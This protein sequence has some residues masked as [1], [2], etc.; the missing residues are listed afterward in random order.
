MR[1]KLSETKR[2][3][4]IGRDKSKCHCELLEWSRV[5]PF[6][7]YCPSCH[8]TMVYEDEIIFHKKSKMDKFVEQLVN[9]VDV[10]KK[11]ELLNEYDRIKNIS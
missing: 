5:Y 2:E 9:K 7:V 8:K 4:V 1:K 6:D 11:A 10:D 3:I